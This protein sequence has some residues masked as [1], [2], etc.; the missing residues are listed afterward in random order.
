MTSEQ[1]YHFIFIVDDTEHLCMTMPELRSVIESN[2]Q[3]K[4]REIKF[5]HYNKYNKSISDI[6][7]RK[8][9]LL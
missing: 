5:F 2:T 3:Y 6:Y 4:T 7:Q 9:N 8:F 1:N